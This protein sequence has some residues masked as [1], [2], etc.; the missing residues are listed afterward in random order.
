MNY[1]L[2]IVVLCTAI[3]VE[4]KAQQTMYMS[5]PEAID[6]AKTHSLDAQLSR[7]RYFG[8][9]WT[10]RSYRAEL[11]PSATLSG[12]ILNYNRSTEQVRNY[13]DGKINYVENNQMSNS[14]SLSIT[15]QIPDIGGFL[16]IE[17]YLY[18]LDQFS[19]K[20]TTYSNQ[21]FRISYTQPLR[22]YNSLKWRKKTEPL[23]FENSK[24]KYLDQMEAI[25]IN[26]TRLY[27]AVLSAQSTYRLNLATEEERC[28]LYEQT[29]KRFELG[30][31]NKSELLQL[32]LSMLNAGVAAKR[33]RLELDNARFQLFSY[34]QARDYACVELTVPAY[35]QGMILKEEEVYNCALRNSPHKYLQQLDLLEGERAL[36]EAKSRQGVQLSLHSEIGAYK[37]GKNLRDVYRGLRD[38][39]IIG[40]TLTVPL[41]DWGVSKGRVRVAKANLE[42]TRT[43]IEQANLEFRQNI[44]TQV[45]QFNDQGD[46]CRDALRAEKIAQERYNLTLHRFQAGTIT[47]TEL[48]TAQQE[49]ESAKSQSIAQIQSFWINYYNIQKS[50][51]YDYINNKELSADFDELI[52]EQ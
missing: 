6:F 28:R 35:V 13:E 8:S 38:N 26:V 52:E 4:S 27:F 19:Y 14:L 15:Q 36:A 7:F 24:R 20:E 5:L 2:T 22:P 21:P 9:Y 3:F 46:Q 37:T 51:L 45:C 40:L 39:E 34:L 44:H 29:Q 50:T 30:T 11:L 49:L 1:R 47:V 48:N 12:D 16:S 42:V 43:M 31:V 10:Y 25:S 33:S 23:A 41:F 32:E 18:R 17:S